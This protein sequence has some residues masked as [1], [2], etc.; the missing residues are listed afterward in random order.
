MDFTEVEVHAGEK[1]EK[2]KVRKSETQSTDDSIHRHIGISVFRICRV[3]CY[4][5]NSAEKMRFSVKKFLIEARLYL[6]FLLFIVI[7]NEIHS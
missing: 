3:S 1:T 6:C 2:V 7:Y 5:I 4:R